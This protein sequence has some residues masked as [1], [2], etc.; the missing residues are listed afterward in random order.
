[1]NVIEY[2]R[3]VI[4]KFFQS[5]HTCNENKIQIGSLRITVGHVRHTYCVRSA[6]TVLA[7]K[8]M[9]VFHLAPCDAALEGVGHNTEVLHCVAQIGIGKTSFFPSRCNRAGKTQRLVLATYAFDVARNVFA[10]PL[11]PSV[12]PKNRQRGAVCIPMRTA[13]LQEA[14]RPH[15]KGAIIQPFLQDRTNGIRWDVRIR[16]A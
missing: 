16:T 13:Y 8:L 11:S 9:Y 12:N 5:R 15:R 14:I 6:V 2:S 1:M 4:H 3:P 10:K 7:D